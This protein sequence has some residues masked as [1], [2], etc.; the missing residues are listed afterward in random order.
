MKVT[1]CDACRC[2][3]SGQK[4]ITGYVC[5]NSENKRVHPITGEATYGD[6]ERF[7]CINGAECY[8]S[9][10]PVFIGLLLALVLVVTSVVLV[11]I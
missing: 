7:R 1:S 5:T 4:T 9:Y 3:R 8:K 2:S 10:V 11:L 6:I